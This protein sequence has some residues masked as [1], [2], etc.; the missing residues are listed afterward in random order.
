MAKSHKCDHCGTACTDE[1]H[2]DDKVFCCE[3]CKSVYSLLWANGM[4][5]FYNHLDADGKPVESGGEF[6]FL[7]NEEIRSQVMDFSDGRIGVVRLFLPA[8]HCSACLW[9]LERLHKLNPG[10]V[11]VRVEF[12]KRMAHIRFNEE[13]MNL[14]QLAELLD[15]IGYPPHIRL[16]DGEE[17]VK[18]TKDRRL[19]YQF[20][21]AAFAFGNIML[22]ALP[23]YLYP[24]D[25]SLQ[26]YS[27]FFR[28]LSVAL[29][30][31]V[32]FYSASDYFINAYKGL[33]IRKVNIDQPIALGITALFAQSMYEILF[34]VGSGYLDSL[35]GLVF[36]L[37][38]GRLFQRKTYESLSFER[39][40]KSYF[41]L[42]ITVIREDG[43]HEIIPVQSVEKG[44]VLYVRNEEIIPVDGTILSGEPIIDNAFVTGESTPVRKAVGDKIFAGGK[45]CGGAI[46]VEVERPMDQSYLTQLWND[47]NF[48][49][50]K[51][52]R[53]HTLTDRV[54]A[55]FISVILILSTGAFAYWTLQGSLG[56]AVHVFTAV[57]IV[58]CPCALALAAPFANGHAMRIMGRN[59][60]YLKKAD[61]IEALG[62]INRVV[63]DKTGTLTSVASS[64]VK[65]KGEELSASDKRALAGLMASSR[66]PLSTRIVAFLQVAF[67]P[68]DSFEEV[69]GSG[70]IGEVNGV[71]WRVGSTQWIGEDGESLP[72]KS[73]VWIEKNG[74][75]IGHFALT[76][77]WREGVSEVVESLAPYAKQTVVTGDDS[78]E[79][80]ALRQLFGDEVDLRFKQ[81]PSDKL[82]V[83]AAL[84]DQSYRVAMI[85]DGLNDAGALNQA[86][87]GISIAE[88]INNFTPASDAILQASVFESLPQF[89]RLARYT[90]KVVY[91][92]FA[93]SFAYNIVGLSFAITGMLSPLLSAILMPLSSIS[94]VAFVSFTVSRFSFAKK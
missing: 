71:K 76:H 46:T 57:L 67:E 14:R 39:D 73:V 56:M 27:T 47:Q 80:G 94:V 17:E 2:L 75:A 20:G 35:A 31:P 45:Q 21:I 44:Q 36:F 54:S 51:S 68:V 19:I 43:K 1:I 42:G 4:E 63:W 78:G 82:K 59:G 84:Q 85:G 93:M 18:S 92:S 58:A 89:F 6:A 34:E 3:G 50:N 10:V 41:P 28:W 79:E 49:G 5:S 13:V 37:L 38:M 30:L 77:A 65:W 86:E 74:E 23:E 69:V 62:E 70:V 26:E 81:K 8:I 33:T 11:S 22:M 53:F 83:V 12:S 90:R 52:D 29:I 7:D 64:E 87:V 91:W 32:L 61:V 48:H 24:E 16:A 25:N 15:K 72:N 88:D 66:H 55:Y 40:Y 60:L 9:L